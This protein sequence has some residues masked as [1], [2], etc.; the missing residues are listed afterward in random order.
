[1]KSNQNTNS[2]GSSTKWQ[3][4]SFS[5]PKSYSTGGYNTAHFYTPPPIRKEPRVIEEIIYVPVI[6]NVLVPQHLNP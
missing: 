1:M 6:H 4:A 5:R 3:E 2:F